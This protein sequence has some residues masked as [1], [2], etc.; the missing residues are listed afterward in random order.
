LTS[1]TLFNSPSR[2]PY[3]LCTTSPSSERELAAENGCEWSFISP[4]ASVP[5]RMPMSL[6]HN[7]VELRKSVLVGA[8][9][10]AGD[11]IAIL[12]A[13]G[14]VK[15]LS[16]DG[17]RDGGLC[18][19]A[20]KNPMNLKIRLSRQDR[21]HPTSL[22]FQESSEGLRI[23]AVDRHGELIVK[24][25]TDGPYPPP[26]RGGIDELEGTEL[27]PRVPELETLTTPVH[28]A[29]PPDHQAMRFSSTR[30]VQP[31]FSRSI[32]SP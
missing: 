17:N 13:S 18:C 3:V 11:L 5:A 29:Y 23:F 14:R 15:L 9:T 27:G 8:A 21:A 10:S 20:S 16:L 28:N 4:V 26:A 22:R 25:L 6:Q 30:P 2:K 7:I 19:H 12:E 31:A 32:S 1:A 24:T